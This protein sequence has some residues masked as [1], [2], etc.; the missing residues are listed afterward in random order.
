M[1]KKKVHGLDAIRTH[2]ATKQ[3]TDAELVEYARKDKASH[4]LD[5]AK[6]VRA[7]RNKKKKAG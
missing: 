5:G 3:M 7:L 1:K 4:R 2:E 6:L